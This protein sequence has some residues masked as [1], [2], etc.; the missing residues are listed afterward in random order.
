MTATDILNST[1]QA[2][3]LISKTEISEEELLNLHKMVDDY[4]STLQRLWFLMID[5]NNTVGSLRGKSEKDRTPVD[6]VSLK[7]LSTV[8]DFMALKFGEKDYFRK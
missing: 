2:H 1:S 3:T 6:N 4:G 5:I 8:R 7:L